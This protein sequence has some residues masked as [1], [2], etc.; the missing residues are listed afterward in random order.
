MSCGR[1]RSTGASAAKAN[2]FNERYRQDHILRTEGKSSTVEERGFFGSYT[3][4]IQNQS[5]SYEIDYPGWLTGSTTVTYNDQEVVVKENGWTTRRVVKDGDEIKVKDGALWPST[6][7]R[8]KKNSDGWTD[9][10]GAFWGTS[11]RYRVE[12]GQ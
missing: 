12:G 1:A 9:S 7:S 3:A 8:T 5:G 2:D 4:G 6:L 11:Y 10:E